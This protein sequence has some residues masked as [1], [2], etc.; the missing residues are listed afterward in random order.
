MPEPAEKTGQ[1]VD[2]FKELENRK[3]FELEHEDNALNDVAHQWLSETPLLAVKQKKNKIDKTK[4]EEDIKEEETK[5]KE[6]KPEIPPPEHVSQKMQDEEK[7]KADQVG[8]SLSGEA[9]T[10]PTGSASAEVVGAV[11]K[12][13]PAPKKLEYDGEDIT[14][15][16]EDSI[17]RQLRG[18]FRH[19]DYEQWCGFTIEAFLDNPINV[20][21][22]GT[23]SGEF[24]MKIVLK[25]GINHQNKK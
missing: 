1:E 5:E 8:S 2:E 20:T 9:P 19:C 17:L 14:G 18:C 6:T 21:C 4:I 16:E 15:N 12:A 23:N 11:A 10:A 24:M 22:S 25:T 7:Q 3:E 13:R